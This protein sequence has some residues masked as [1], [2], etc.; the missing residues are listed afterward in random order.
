MKPVFSILLAV[1]VLAVTVSANPKNKTRA[2]GVT[3]LIASNPKI[4]D[5]SLLRTL[6]RFQVRR[7]AEKQWEFTPRPAHALML[8]KPATKPLP[9]PQ[10]GSDWAK[11]EFYAGYAFTYFNVNDATNL[12]GWNSSV[13][14]YPTRHLGIVADFGGGYVSDTLFD[15][16]TLFK[17][18]GSLHTFLFGPRLRAGNDRVTGFI[19]GLAGVSRVQVTGTVTIAGQ[20][21]RDDITEKAFA[22][23]LGAGFDVRLNDRI[24]LRVIQA[25]YLLSRFLDQNQHS[26]RASTGLVFR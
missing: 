26:V 8:P 10:G 14:V 24:S 11:I 7:P 18:D 15:D 13:T 6:T 20:T 3:R 16:G 21:I 25:D 23:A 4:G 17:G 5:Y 19:H 2:A 22:A 1:C 9:R 12:H